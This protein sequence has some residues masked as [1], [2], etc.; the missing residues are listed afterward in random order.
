[1]LGLG[2]SNAK[3]GGPIITRFDIELQQQNS[4]GLETPKVI[5][6]SYSKGKNNN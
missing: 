3:S 6:E 4:T 2:R 5:E 1:V